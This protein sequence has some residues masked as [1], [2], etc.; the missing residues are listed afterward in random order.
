MPYAWLHAVIF[1]LFSDTAYLFLHENTCIYAYYFVFFFNHTI[2]IRV[3][4]FNLIA[5]MHAG[6]TG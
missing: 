4:T 3:T 2:N 6:E 5:L 1:T